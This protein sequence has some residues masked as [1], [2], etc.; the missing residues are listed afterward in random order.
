MPATETK[1]EPYRIQPDCLLAVTDY[2]KELAG[3][4]AKATDSDHQ[5]SLVKLMIMSAT[6][7]KN[8]A[9]KAIRW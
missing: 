8:S 3:Q 5:K 1:L 4:V 6:A 2:A 9:P 7:E